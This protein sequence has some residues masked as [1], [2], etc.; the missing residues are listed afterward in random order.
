MEGIRRW[1]PTICLTHF[2]HARKNSKFTMRRQKAS[3][4]LRWQNIDLYLTHGE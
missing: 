3:E 4:Q 1:F 2:S